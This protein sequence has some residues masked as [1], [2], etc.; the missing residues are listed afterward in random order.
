MRIPLPPP[1]RLIALWIAG[2]DAMNTAR[3]VIRL[4]RQVAEATALVSPADVSQSASSVE[5]SRFELLSSE[6]A[7]AFPAIEP[8]SPPLCHHI[9]SRA[10]ASHSG[11]V[12]TNHVRRSQP[13]SSVSVTNHRSSV[14]ISP[15]LQAT[16]GSRAFTPAWMSFATQQRPRITTLGLGRTLLAPSPNAVPWPAPGAIPSGRCALEP[17]ILAVAHL[18]AAPICARYGP[19]SNSCHSDVPP[20]VNSVAPITRLPCSAFHSLMYR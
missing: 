19:T 5:V 2:S 13:Q 7:S 14:V 17:C 18:N 9:R 8:V 4:W 11:H 20:Q 15:C 3:S 6:R 10:H 1:S 12:S 16:P